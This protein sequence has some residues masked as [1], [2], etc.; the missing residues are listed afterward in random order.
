MT[1]PMT[2]PITRPDGADVDHGAASPVG[3]SKGSIA[4]AAVAGTGVD[5]MATAIRLTR[6][7]ALVGAMLGIVE[8]IR[9]M[10]PEAGAARAGTSPLHSDGL[11]PAPA[12]HEYR[13]V[14]MNGFP[15]SARGRRVV[16]L[17]RVS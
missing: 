5:G 7:G 11:P 16:V 1:R 4:V 3:C 14:V 6:R 12:G 17:V 8:G 9:R 10:T 15:V 2:R 13:D